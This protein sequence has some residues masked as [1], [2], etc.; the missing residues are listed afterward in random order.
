MSIGVDRLL[1]AIKQINEIKVENNEPILS[2]YWKKSLCK[3]II[4]F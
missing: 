2:V 3:I 1:F 4:Q